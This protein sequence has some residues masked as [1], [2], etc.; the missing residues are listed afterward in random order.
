VSRIHA[1]RTPRAGASDYA[2]VERAIRFLEAHAREQPT[3]AETAAEVGLS[4]FHFQ[5]LFERWAGITPKRFVQ[6]LTL[7]HAKELLRASQSLLDTSA[8][9]GLSGPSRLH[10]LFLTIERMTPGQYKERARG[11]VIEY[12]VEPTPFGP[13]LVAA[14]DGALCAVSFVQ[15]GGEGE[16][17]RELQE[18]WPD[19]ALRHA[20]PATRRHGEVLRARMEGHLDRPLGIL[21]KGTALQLKVWEALLH[22]PVGCVLSYRHVA[23]LAGAPAAARA[24]GNAI[25]HNAL[26]YLIPCHRV[27]RSTG[28]LGGYRWG[29][30]RK[31][32]IL[33]REQ[34][35]AGEGRREWDSKALRRE[36]DSNPRYPHGHT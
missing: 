34:A 36:W 23:D 29:V 15:D 12:A 9:V 13:A 25:G 24:V 14:L 8:E 20:P 26:A 33:A 27:L 11:L 16:A 2:R 4:E 31:R 10:D 21:L 5:R 30:T 17:M 22:I 18:R 1:E 28:S 19:A 32:A 35:I 6:Y 7:Q 3:L